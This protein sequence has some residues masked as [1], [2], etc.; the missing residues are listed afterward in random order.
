[1]HSKSHVSDTSIVAVLFDLSLYMLCWSSDLTPELLKLAI[2]SDLLLGDSF[3]CSVSFGLTQVSIPV[4]I[5]TVSERLY[6]F[7]TFIRLF[8]RKS[9]YIFHWNYLIFLCSRSHH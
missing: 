5:S 6:R 8:I 2:A 7:Y 3:D 1:M 4:S 9:S